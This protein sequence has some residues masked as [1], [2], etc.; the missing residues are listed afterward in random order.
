MEVWGYYLIDNSHCKMYSVIEIYIWQFCIDLY[1]APCIGLKFKKCR[2]LIFVL[3][4]PIPPT[5]D[6]STW[7][8]FQATSRAWWIASAGGKIPSRFEA[9]VTRWLDCLLNLWPFL[10]MKICPIVLNFAKVGSKFCPKLNKHSNKWQRFFI[11]LPL[12]QIWSHWTSNV[13]SKYYPLY[14]NKYFW[15]FYLKALN[16]ISRYIFHLKIHI[17]GPLFLYFRFFSRKNVVL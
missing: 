17:S 2:P 16:C 6:Y 10:I 15:L 7:W 5:S 14:W 4:P 9:S 12:S 8:L 1:A 13:S 3:A 11:F